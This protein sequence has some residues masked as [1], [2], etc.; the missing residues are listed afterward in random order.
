MWN[1]RTIIVVSRSTFLH[2]LVL[3][4]RRFPLLNREKDSQTVLLCAC[5]LSTRCKKTSFV[6]LCDQMHPECTCSWRNS[7]D[8]VHKRIREVF[9]QKIFIKIL[10][11]TCYLQYQSLFRDVFLLQEGRLHTNMLKYTYRL[12]KIGFLHLQLMCVLT[13]C[14]QTH[15]CSS[16]TD[17]GCGGA[18]MYVTLSSLIYLHS[19]D[20]AQVLAGQIG[21]GWRRLV[22]LTESWGGSCFLHALSDVQLK[23]SARNK[24]SV[25]HSVQRARLLMLPWWIKD[26]LLLP[27]LETVGSKIWGSPCSIFIAFIGIV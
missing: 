17:G 22:R 27:Q 13:V 11:S 2:L 26:C 7:P 1:N 23:V 16:G 6:C 18:D 21:L 15:S 5:V 20:V 10:I 19:P 9:F 14:T 4:K 8:S 3:G 25:R 12:I 24:S